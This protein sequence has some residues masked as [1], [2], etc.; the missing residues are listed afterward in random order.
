MSND[1]I[2]YEKFVQNVMQAILNAEGGQ[3]NIEVEHNVRLKGNSGAKRQFDVYWEYKQAVIVHK[4]VIECKDYSRKISIDKIDALKGKL[5]DFPGITG[6]I[7]THKG[8]ESGAK[9][10]AQNRGIHALIIRPLNEKTD[11]KTKD[12]EPLI[13]RVEINMVCMPGL[14]IKSLECLLDKEYVKEHNLDNLVGHR[15]LYDPQN[16]MLEDGKTKRTVTMVSELMNMMITDDVSKTA[17]EY[18]VTR[19]FEDTFVIYEDGTRCKLKAI[20]LTYTRPAPITNKITFDMA[21]YIKA[22]VEYLETGEKKMVFTD[23]KTTNIE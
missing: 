23:G 5:D 10:Y 8:Y 9:T 21:D 11:F 13:R 3:Q 22:V 15:R 17:K 6:L 20:H 4:T 18:E 7:A 16:I 19:E 1:G 12:G 2:G 14:Q